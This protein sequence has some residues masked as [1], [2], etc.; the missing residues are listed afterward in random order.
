MEPKS[1]EQK[2]KISELKNY[3][4]LKS[5]L[6][7]SLKKNIDIKNL[8]IEEYLI[9]LH[10]IIFNSAG[11]NSEEEY[12]NK[13]ETLILCLIE[14]SERISDNINLFK[15]ISSFTQILFEL[16]IKTLKEKANTN[17]TQFSVKVLAILNSEE[18]IKKAGLDKK[19]IEDLINYDR[20]NKAYNSLKIKIINK[21]AC[22]ILVFFPELVKSKDEKINGFVN[23]FLKE[24]QINKFYKIYEGKENEADEDK[25][26]EKD[27]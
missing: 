17:I 6:T 22:Y 3:D 20:F 4:T 21:Y 12:V 15:Y 2:K 9:E 13:L 27:K 23:K 8:S 14:N 7:Y 11:I 1:D 5:L 19:E 18:I 24:K 16:L 25:P 10:K 26:N